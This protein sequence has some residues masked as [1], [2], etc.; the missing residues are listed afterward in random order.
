MFGNNAI[1]SAV[2]ASV[3]RALSS[4]LSPANSG[5]PQEMELEVG[6]RQAGQSHWAAS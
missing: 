1:C 2:A 4:R 3:R 5:E 6:Q